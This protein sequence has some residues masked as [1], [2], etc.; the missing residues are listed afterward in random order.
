MRSGQGLRR[1]DYR[2]VR[3][4][5]YFRYLGADIGDTEIRTH[6]VLHSHIT[7]GRYGLFPSPPTCPCIPLVPQHMKGSS[8]HPC[9]HTW[10]SL[11][12]LSTAAKCLPSRSMKMLPSFPLV[13]KLCR[14]LNMA[15]KS[16]G[17]GALRSVV[18]V[19][20]KR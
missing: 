20:V 7:D 19:V 15:E 17:E 11:R 2:L 18:T 9:V 14:P 4:L 1:G 10:P 3:D 8:P 13:S 6:P 12:K 5:S 16:D